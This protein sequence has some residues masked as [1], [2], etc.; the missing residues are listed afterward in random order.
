MAA[1]ATAKASILHKLPARPRSSRQQRA[2][3]LELRA[4]TQ[5]LRGCRRSRP[6]GKRAHDLLAPIYAW[7]TEG[8]ETADLNYVKGLLDEVRSR[9][10]KRLSDSSGP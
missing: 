9:P 4:A 7:F 5:P 1:A 10:C 6:S 2:K 3:S 8:F